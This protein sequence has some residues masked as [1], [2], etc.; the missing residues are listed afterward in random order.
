[1]LSVILATLTKAWHGNPVKIAASIRSLILLGTSFGL[2]WTADQVAAVMV[3][4][5]AI[6]A[7]FTDNVVTSNVHVD[8]MVEQAVRRDRAFNTPGV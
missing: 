1:M 3:A 4:V 7:L 8:S 5:E 2:H 6:L